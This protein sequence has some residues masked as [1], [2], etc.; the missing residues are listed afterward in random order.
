MKKIDM[1]MKDNFLDEGRLI[2]LEKLIDN[3][4][5]AWYLQKGTIPELNDDYW[6]CH[7]VYDDDEP[8][9]DLYNPVIEIF[10]E[11]LKYA[12]LCRLT[13]NLFHR[14]E[15]PS[16]SDFHADFNVEKIT[17]AI[18]YLNTNNGYVEFEGGDKID[19]VRNRLI[20]FPAIT[21]HKVIGQTDE[22][23]R[24][25]LNFN[26]VEWKRHGLANEAGRNGSE[27]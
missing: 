23:R 7:K 27:G 6:F 20:M 12:S 11:Y 24:I 4:Y 8:R 5:F 19:C 10:K 16:I 14:Q 15:T 18:F 17:T 3:P 22:S 25:V 21:K 2:V 26:I 1:K 9:S 13:I